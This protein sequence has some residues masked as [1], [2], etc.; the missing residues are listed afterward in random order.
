MLL[1]LLLFA[2]YYLARNRQFK[3]PDK[4]DF[5]PV[6]YLKDLTLLILLSLPYF[7]LSAFQMFDFLHHE[8]RL[9]QMDVAFWANLVDVLRLT[10]N[11]NINF[12]ANFYPDLIPIK[13][14]TA[15]HYYELWFSSFITD[16]THVPSS[17]SFIMLTATFLKVNMIVL[18]ISFWELKGR[19]TFAKI[20]LTYLIIDVFIPPLINVQLFPDLSPIIGYFQGFHIHEVRAPKYLPTTL[21]MLVGVHLLYRQK[22]IPA[23]LSISVIAFINVVVITTLGATLFLGILILTIKKKL[24]WAWMAYP[25][26]LIGISYGFYAIYGDSSSSAYLGE[27]LLVNLMKDPF[28]IEYFKTIVVHQIIFGSMTTLFLLPFLILFLFNWR[29]LMKFR[30]ILIAALL[31]LMSASLSVSL[32]TGMYNSIQFFT[33]LIPAFALLA[34]LGLIEL[35]DNIPRIQRSLIL[36]LT[37]GCTIGSIASYVFMVGHHEPNLIGFHHFTKKDMD[38]GNNIFPKGKNHIPVAIVKEGAKYSEDHL[39][40]IMPT[41][42]ANEQY[43]VM[44][45]IATER[46]YIENLDTTDNIEIDFC[47]NREPFWVYAQKERANGISDDEMQVNFIRE[48]DINYLILKRSDEI[49][50][51]FRSMIS[52]TL[53]VQHNGSVLYSLDH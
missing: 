1:L 19:L 8:I 53:W 20:A 47:H 9:A 35:W 6:S 33:N 51:H 12:R 15:Y 16:I 26:L 24:K 50:V 13:G 23:I 29:L 17:H 27:S 21:F 18:F 34:T 4:K 30:S 43:E 7:L 3:L 42:H 11:E 45:N 49:P 5:L 44:V 32:F 46:T 38:H 52:D 39:A 31:I 10:G 2:G 37:V 41:L 22:Y 36:I 40:Y 14:I 25:F 28:N 48:H